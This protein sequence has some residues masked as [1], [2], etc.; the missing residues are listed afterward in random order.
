MLP[1]LS[2]QPRSPVA[3]PSPPPPPPLNMTARAVRRLDLEEHAAEYQRSPSPERSANSVVEESPPPLDDVSP[4]SPASPAI[5]CSQYRLEEYERQ[6]G[7]PAGYEKVGG[8]LRD[9]KAANESEGPEPPRD[10]Y[11]TPPAA[12]RKDQYVE[13]TYSDRSDSFPRARV[14]PA[15]LFRD[16]R[17]MF[18]NTYQGRRPFTFVDTGLYEGGRH[19]WYGV[20]NERDLVWAHRLD[21]ILKRH[22]VPRRVPAGNPPWA[23]DYN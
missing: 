2:T 8:W 3:S 19:D 5:Y 7:P 12:P 20:H 6:N 23:A 10:R 16:G 11:P 13:D 17:L 4:V 18:H 22:K 1:T 21:M 9:V 14:P 15:H